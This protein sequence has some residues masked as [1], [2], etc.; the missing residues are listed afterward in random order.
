VA[1]RAREE[2]T[3]ND[4]RPGSFLQVTP[5][6]R[7]L[8]CTATEVRTFLTR[9]RFV[10]NRRV[11]SATLGQL[12]APP[13][14]GRRPARNPSGIRLPATSLMFEVV[15]RGS[16]L[17]SSPRSGGLFAG[18]ADR[19]QDASWSLTRKGSLVRAQQRPHVL[20][21]FRGRMASSPTGHP[22]PPG[23]L[24]AVWRSGTPVRRHP[25]DASP[26]R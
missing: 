25:S 15:H 16:L 7:P 19:P 17:R 5:E 21:Q 18:G 4:K 1:V 2:P 6:I 9:K 11:L 13:S 24:Q 23:R 26:E 14:L 20:P 22:R 3:N 8:T 10:L 12:G